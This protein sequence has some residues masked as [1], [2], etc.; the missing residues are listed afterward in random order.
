MS[1]DDPKRLKPENRTQLWRERHLN[2]H[3]EDRTLLYFN[4]IIAHWNITEFHAKKKED[5]Q[6]TCWWRKEDKQG[7]FGKTKTKTFGMSLLGCIIY[8]Y[9]NQPFSR[10]A[11]LRKETNRIQEFFEGVRRSLAE[12][13]N[14]KVPPVTSRERYETAY[15]TSPDWGGEEALTVQR[16]NRARRK[17]YKLKEI[18]EEEE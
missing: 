7:D 6:W 1:I 16:Q 14:L 2:I 17:E 8:L 3:W 15:Y 12:H 10:V 4:R 13:L 18:K 9:R 11:K 5:G